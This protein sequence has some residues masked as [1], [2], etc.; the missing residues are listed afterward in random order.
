[1]TMDQLAKMENPLQETNEFLLCLSGGVLEEQLKIAKISDE[2]K[3][4]IR[5]KY[6]D[7]KR[8]IKQAS[9]SWVRYND[10]DRPEIAA[11]M[12]SFGVLLASGPEKKTQLIGL[13]EKVITM[14]ERINVLD[15]ALMEMLAEIWPKAEWPQMLPA[16]SDGD[17]PSGAEWPRYRLKEIFETK[18][19]RAMEFLLNSYNTLYKSGIQEAT[20]A[21]KQKKVRLDAIVRTLDTCLAFMNALS[22]ILC[23]V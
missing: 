15:T 22:R 9:D 16:F 2:Q 21:L 17:I 11:V 7:T 6:D 8:E 12:L 13:I 10:K 14:A 18:H 19:A 23:R 20:A 5:L 1:M 3:S 4:L